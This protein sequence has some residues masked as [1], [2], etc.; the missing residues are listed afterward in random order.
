MKNKTRSLLL[1][2]AQTGLIPL[3]FFAVGCSTSKEKPLVSRG[4]VGGHV[5]VV[6]D[7]PKL[8][9]PHPK[10]ALL[11][12]SLATNTPA[13]VAGLR[14]GDLI[15]ALDRQPVQKL[16]QF[17]GK[18]DPLTPGT[19]LVLT[20]WRDGQIQ[21]YKVTVGRETFRKGGYF[22]LFFPLVVYGFDPWPHGD[23]PRFSLI[24]AGYA[25]NSAHRVERGSV[26]EQYDLKC[27]PKDTQYVEDEKLWLIFM[28]FSN[29][30]RIAGQE[31]AEAAK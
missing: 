24:V 12:T 5:A 19:N 16:R 26:K 27:D 18:I 7:F 30:K 15:L 1:V 23:T 28:E 25:N 20:A 17:R 11:I 8:M 2:L 6:T 22:T 10:T 21:D 3:L 31:L 9:I 4:W 29:G 14:E 13:A